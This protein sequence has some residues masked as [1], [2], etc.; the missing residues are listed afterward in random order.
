MAVEFLMMAQPRGEESG[1]GPA[2][3]CCAEGS[4]DNSRR[5]RSPPSRWRRGGIPGTGKS[6]RKNGRGGPVS[7]ACGRGTEVGVSRAE[8]APP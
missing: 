4:Q 7:R 2:R 5:S 3:L 8:V 6:N 1:C